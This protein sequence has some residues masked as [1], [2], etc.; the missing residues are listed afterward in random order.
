MRRLLTPSP[1]STFVFVVDSA[2]QVQGPSPRH[3]VETARSSR[4]FLLRER[5]LPDWTSE[6]RL[7]VVALL[8]CESEIHK[9]HFWSDSKKVTIH[10]LSQPNS[11]R[12]G[13]LKLSLTALAISI[14]IIMQGVP[15]ARRPRCVCSSILPRSFCLMPIIRIIV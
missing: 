6:V 11:V 9:I 15:T 1:S 14:I 12:S 3:K 5:F 2:A 10:R 7:Q 13:K 4:R 8:S